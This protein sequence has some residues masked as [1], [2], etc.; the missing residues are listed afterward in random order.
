MK[1][2]GDKAA[3]GTKGDQGPQGAA[4]NGITRPVVVLVI[5]KIKV[6]KE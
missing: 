5:K 2:Q 3:Q 1:N 6:Q 4:A